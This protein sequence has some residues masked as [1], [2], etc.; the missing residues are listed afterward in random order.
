MNMLCCMFLPK[1]KVFSMKFE[2]DFSIEGNEYAPEKDESETTKSK[3]NSSP[4]NF[5]AT[6]EE[7][8]SSSSSSSDPKKP[9]PTKIM[10]GNLSSSIDATDLRELFE[11]HGRVSEVDVDVRG[12][13]LVV[14]PD[15]EEA[16]M[17]VEALNDQV[18]DGKEIVV[19]KYSYSSK[20]CI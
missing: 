19:E 12:F 7:R 5:G 3:N 8:F 13:A 2:V 11:K 15:P 10:V 6:S 4:R 20:L 18:V 9:L 14:M 17:A 16:G 1:K